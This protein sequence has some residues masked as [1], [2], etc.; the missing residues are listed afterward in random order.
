MEEKDVSQEILVELLKDFADEELLG[1]LSII[2]A[3]PEES[4]SIVG[5]AF[6]DNYEKNLNSMQSKT[7][8]AQLLNAGGIS[9][10]ELQETLEELDGALEQGELKELLSPAKKSF[11][12]KFFSITVNAVAET[13]GIASRVIQIPVEVLNEDAVVPSYVKEGDAGMDVYSLEEYIID[14][15]QTILIPTGLKVALPRGYELQVRPRS[16]MSLKT[17]LR[18][19]NSPGTIDSGYR[20]EIGIIVENTNPKIKDLEV[21]YGDDGEA[22][23]KSILYGEAIVIE[24][25]QRFAQLVLNQVP[26]AAFFEVDNVGEFGAD[27]GGGFGSTGLGVEDQKDGED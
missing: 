17:K 6:L 15:G 16:G 23:V 11:L 22:K 26:M 20:D 12:R 21:E 3:L 27:R 14:P 1:E 5:L 4:F 10:E 2:L 24:K 18:V 9:V 19:A 7:A 8:I 25:G 13:E